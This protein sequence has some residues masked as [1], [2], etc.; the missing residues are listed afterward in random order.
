MTSDTLVYLLFGLIGVVVLLVILKWPYFGIAV[1][2]SILPIVH[3]FPDI[4][5]FSSIA[6]PVGLVTLAAYLLQS[7]GTK[8]RQKRKLEPVYLFG[9]LFILWVVVS[10]PEASILGKDRVWFLTFVQLWILMF[11]TGELLDTPEHQKV[12]MLIYAIASTVSAFYAISQGEITEDALSSAR[13]AGLAV[14]ANQAAR[15]YVMALVC[16]YYLRS[17]STESLPKLLYLMGMIVTFVGVFFTVSRSGIL[18]LLGTFLLILIFQPKVQN[19][20]SLIVLLSVMLVI[21]SFFSESIFQIIRGIFPAIR[22]GT[23]TV[24][25][26]YDLWRAGLK[27]WLDYPVQGIGIGQYNVNLLRYMKLV[28]GA[29]RGGLSPH[30]T[31]IHVLAE[32]GLVGFILFM[33]MLASAFRHLWPS[34]SRR[35]ENNEELRN[36]WFIVLLII[37]VGG[38][39]ITDLANKILWV[40]LGVSVVFA[41][42]NIDVSDNKLT[43]E[44]KP[45]KTSATSIR[46]RRWMKKVK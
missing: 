10:N 40:V 36:I 20:I 27:M 18:L 42:S 6:T 16:F 46:M 28:G 5:L 41:K 35:T 29:E 1:S 2:I 4:P 38:I 44:L 33:G 30:N 34:I 43:G 26:R 9:F 21:M 7:K 32:T 24:G 14:N 19:K 22:M 17:K 23:D 39:T 25:L 8:K 12:T 3:I 31:Y 13:V 15:Y 11:L 45:A 37:S